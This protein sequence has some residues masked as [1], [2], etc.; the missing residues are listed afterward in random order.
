MAHKTPQ[1]C[2]PLTAGMKAPKLT[3]HMVPCTPLTLQSP[4]PKQH[5][6]QFSRFRRTHSHDQQT[7]A[8]TD[9]ATFIATGRA[10]SKVDASGEMIPHYYY[11]YNYTT[12]VQRPLFQD[13]LVKPAKER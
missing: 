11:N 9:H 7:L 13:N 10:Y 6:D 12:P 1:S 3:S 4:Q 5:L 2:H 8:E